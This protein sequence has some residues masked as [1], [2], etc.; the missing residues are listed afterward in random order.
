M[1]PSTGRRN[2]METLRRNLRE[3]LDD[4]E[5]RRAVDSRIEQFLA[6]RRDR[7]DEDW[8]SELCFCILTA[9]STAKLGLEIQEALGDRCL[10]LSRN[11]MQA[12]LV[13][14]GHRFP[15]VRSDYICRARKFKGIASRIESFDDDRA[16]REWLVENVKGLGYKEA[17][18]FLRNT[19]HFDV[20][21]L[22]RHIIRI[23]Y[24]HNLIPEMPAS[25]TRTRYMECEE[26]LSELSEK[27]GI[28]LGV[29]DLYLWYTKTGEVLK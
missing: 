13:E 7:K 6:M 2:G 25:L 12:L 22:D 15:N 26:I 27:V 8:F 10:T 9:N 20:A 17:S 14:H 5:L 29:S 19:G 16:A 23:L 1:T 3:L 21:I 11:D 24:E 18:H 28:P 4:P